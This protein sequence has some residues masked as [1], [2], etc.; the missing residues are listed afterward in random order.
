MSWISNWK[1]RITGAK[2]ALG[3]VRAM[4]ST[5]TQ[6]V[7]AGAGLG[8]VLAEKVI[9]M[10]RAWFGATDWIWSVEYDDELTVVIGLVLVPLI[11]RV[12]G[13]WRDPIKSE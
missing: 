9:D 12:L 4:Q 3:V 7:A 13:F 11:S 6:N 5:T 8:Y 1:R 2:K 10:L